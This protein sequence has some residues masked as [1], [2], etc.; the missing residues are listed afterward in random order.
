MTLYLDCNATTPIDPRVRSELLRVL[1]QEFGNAGSPHEF[2]ERAKGIVN[3]AR[4]QVGR[5]VAARRHEVVF[6]SGATESNNLALLGLEP[7]GRQTGKRHVVS[8]MIEHKAVL[9]PLNVLRSRGFEV[10]QIPPTAAG[11][12][13]AD[14]VLRAVRDDTL[15]VS[16][17]HVNNETGV[18]QPIAEI[19]AGLMQRETILHVDAAQGFARDLLPLQ[20]PRIDLISIS[21]HKIH[22]PQGV[23]ALVA[24]RRNGALPPLRPIV[25]GGGQE[26][27]LRSGTLPVH[28]V[29]ALGTAAELA[30]REAESRRTHCQR[31]REVVLAWLREHQATI[32]GDPSCTLPHVVNASFVPWSSDQVMETFRGILAVSDGA[33]CTTVCATASH[34]LAAMGASEPDLSGAIRLS[35]S[36]LTPLDQLE[37]ALTRATERLR[38]LHEGA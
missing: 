20:H 16:V 26:F 19:A 6:T 30:H 3:R 18:V 17:M 25:H 13:Q 12:I 14:A 23:G 9:E 35:W 28:L 24:R 21:G 11:R 22:A 2:G 10:T 38:T 1:E 29:A 5:V 36:Y 33:A 4:E 8:T 27:G 15:A 37:L 32:H 34:V 31:V 7:H